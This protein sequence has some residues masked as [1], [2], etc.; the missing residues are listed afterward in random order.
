CPWNHGRGPV[1]WPEFAPGT[2]DG[3]RA[4]SRPTT[5]EAPSADGPALNLFDLLALDDEG[6]RRQF[7]GS[8]IKRAKRSGLLRN[9]VVALGN[10][11]DRRAVPALARAL[12]GDPDPLVRAHAAWALGR[13]G[14]RQAEAA[15]DEAYQRETDPEVGAEAPTES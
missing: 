9:A 10:S 15:L 8:P 13:L 2:A 11:G 6:F 4:A 5:E 7:R 12:A 3:G 14:G 1:P